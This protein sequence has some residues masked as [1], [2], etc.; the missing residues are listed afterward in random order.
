MVN[1]ANNKNKENGF[2]L[3]NLKKDFNDG[4]Q[5]VGAF[6]KKFKFKPLDLKSRCTDSI[7]DEIILSQE[8]LIVL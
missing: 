3:S 2:D 8:D 7:D 6:D 5:S 1:Q 4:H